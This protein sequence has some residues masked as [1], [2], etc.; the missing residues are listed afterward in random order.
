MARQLEAQGETVEALLLLDSATPAVGEVLSAVADDDLPAFLVTQLPGSPW[1]SLTSSRRTW[2]P[3]PG[4]RLRAVYERIGGLDAL[5]Q[6][7]DEAWLRRYVRLWTARM[8]GL[9]STPPRPRLRRARRPLPCST[10]PLGPAV[11]AVPAAMAEPEP[12]GWERL[13]REAVEEH[14]APGTHH[15]LVGEPPAPTLGADRDRPHPPLPDL[16]GGCRGA[17]GVSPARRR[18]R[19][20]PPSGEGL[21]VRARILCRVLLRRAR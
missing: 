2:G 6:D 1:T 18:Q 20:S 17:A 19:K 11:P 12:L 9:R 5:P 13:C 21:R 14:T 7:A 16:S 15:T 10:E 8:S 4:G 3:R